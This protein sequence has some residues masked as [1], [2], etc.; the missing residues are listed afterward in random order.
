MN[1]QAH[2][3]LERALDAIL[4]VA[5]PALGVITSL[6]EQVEYA[7]RICSLLLGISVGAVALYRSLKKP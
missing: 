2:S 4:G 1:Q 5:A 3:P 6:Q 7:L